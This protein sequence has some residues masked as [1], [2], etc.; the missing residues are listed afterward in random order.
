[1]SEDLIINESKIFTDPSLFGVVNAI[2][3][4]KYLVFHHTGCQNPDRAIGMY[5]QYGVSAHYLID[6]K[7]VIFRLVIDNNI[8]YHAGVSNWR[9]VESLNQNSIGIELLSPNPHQ[10]GFSDDQIKS[11][12]TL[13][14][15]LIS[16][17]NI[18]PQ[19]IVGHS[20]IAYDLNTR[21]LNRK[22]DPSHLFP[23]ARLA[24]AGIGLFPDQISIKQPD[25]ILFKIG[26]RNPDI[27]KVRDVLAKIGY[28]VKQAVDKYDEGLAKAIRCFNRHYNPELFVKDPDKSEAENYSLPLSGAAFQLWSSSL[29]KL[30]DLMQT[31]ATN[32]NNSSNQIIF[33]PIIPKL[34]SQNPKSD[35]HPALIFAVSAAGLLLV[36][37]LACFL[38]KS[39]NKTTNSVTPYENLSKITA[40]RSKPISAIAAK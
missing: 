36:V 15:E 28:H 19:N 30:N 38:W 16:T 3:A 34:H 4:V 11:L 20:D 14:Q 31:I 18:F 29:Q 40:D 32:H 24:K 33:E 2:R 17:Y 26:D 13:C 1:M 35:Y 5:Q 8:A 37:L 23:W 27:I 6:Q 21:Y 10:D 22:Q 25:S 7:G 9:G 39:Y 12:I